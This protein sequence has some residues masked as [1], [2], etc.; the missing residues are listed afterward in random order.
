MSSWRELNARGGMEAVLPELQAPFIDAATK[1]I[2]VLPD[3]PALEVTQVA[4][5]REAATALRL[6]GSRF[7]GAAA[8]TKSGFVPAP[9]APAAPA[10]TLT[11]AEPVAMS[12]TGA[13]GLSPSVTRSIGIAAAAGAVYDVATTA[14][15]VSDLR[16]HG[17]LTGAQSEVMHLPDAISVRL[18]ARCWV[19]RCS[20]PLAR[21]PAR[22]IC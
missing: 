17:N 21:K 11:W 2:Y 6:D 12:E 1:G 4:V 13:R 8:L 19:R 22:W 10:A 16:Q 9:L 18:V 15:R 14:S 3:N 7:V 20:V 5:S